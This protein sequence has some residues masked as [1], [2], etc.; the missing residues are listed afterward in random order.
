MSKNIRWGRITGASDDK[1]PYKLHSVETDGKV[2]DMMALD[3][4]GVQ[5]NAMKDGQCLVLVPDGDEGKAVMI[6]L[7]PPA[8]RIDGQ[9]EGE[10][11]YNN[12]VTGNVIKHD[13]DGNTTI[14]T[15]GILHINPP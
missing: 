12:P 10:V 1:G 4:F 3:L 5:G 11:S 7:P 14:K 15:S 6:P 9:K 2:M 8:K 13:A